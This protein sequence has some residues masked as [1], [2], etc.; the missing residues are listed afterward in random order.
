MNT[1]S[2]L[3][4][5]LL[6][7]STFLL[8]GRSIHRTHDPYEPTIRVKWSENPQEEAILSSRYIDEYPFFSLFNK[9]FF[10]KHMLPPGKLTFRNSVQ[11]V[12][13]HH[14]ESL[15]EHLLKEIQNKEKNYTHFEVLQQKDFSRRKGCGLLIAKFK[16]YPFVVKLF[17][18]TPHSFTQTWGKGMVPVFLFY[19]GSGVNRHLAGFTRIANLEDIKKRIAH[20]PEWCHRIDL[21]RK[22]FWLPRNA[23]WLEIS[24]TNIGGKAHQYTKIP[25]TYAIVADAIEHSDAASPD[26]VEDDSLSLHICNM[27]EMR[28]DP[29]SNNIIQ[30]KKTNK[31]VLIDTEHFPTI[32]GRDV[33]KHFDGY[34]S[35]IMHLTKHCAKNMFLTT[36][37]HRAY[38]ESSQA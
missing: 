24:G 35:W 12:D 11:T 38:K 8:H 20:N 15:I 13:T 29:H 21:P 28:V 23:Q 32:V 34:F 33:E 4:L 6:I 26:G 5:T 25:A 22:W 30:E 18:E 14:L 16:K 36:K 2:F 10:Y 17:I 1:Q 27:L 9:D 3:K 31:I 7:T 37:K 19:L